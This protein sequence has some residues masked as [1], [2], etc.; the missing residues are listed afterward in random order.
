MEPLDR[1][2]IIEIYGAPKLTFDILASN[3]CNN[4]FEPNGDDIEEN[5]FMKV[6]ID[7]RDVNDEPPKFSEE[8]LFFSMT[9]GGREFRESV[10]I[11]FIF[12]K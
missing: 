11:V 1:E 12:F 3:E 4:D 6:E 8:T 9:T 2:Q 5:T 7:I 10:K